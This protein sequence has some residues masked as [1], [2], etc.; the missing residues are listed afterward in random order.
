MGLKNEIVSAND[1]PVRAVEV[2]HWP[3]VYVRTLSVK[4]L[5]QVT[6]LETG[7]KFDA[8]SLA[9][10]CTLVLCDADGSRVFTDDEFGL[11]LHKPFAALQA[12]VEAALELNGLADAKA[13]EGN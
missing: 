7:D 3:P 4:E 1:L 13:D 8:E 9:K 5:E 10:I 12:I 11:L 2:E 6:R